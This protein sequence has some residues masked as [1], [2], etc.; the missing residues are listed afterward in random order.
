MFIKAKKKAKMT[1][2]TFG[3]FLLVFCLSVSDKAIERF[4]K[5]VHAPLV[6][7]QQQSRLQSSKTFYQFHENK[8]TL[9]QID[10]DSSQLAR[11]PKE[12]GMVLEETMQGVNVK[13]QEIPLGTFAKETKLLKAKEGIFD[14][15]SKTFKASDVEM[16][17][18][19]LD[20][21]DD[22]SPK[23]GVYAHAQEA[24]F[25]LSKTPMHF[26]AKEMM[27]HVLDKAP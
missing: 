15:F 14:Y 25:D 3:C 24:R 9:M 1:L 18:L 17:L 13:I 21:L 27:A 23:K 4:E 10:T 7:K 8:S 12:G 26:S 5:L 2:C 20:Q 16:Q 22:T 19:V 11:V 6:V